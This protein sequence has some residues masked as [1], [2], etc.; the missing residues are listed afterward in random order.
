MSPRRAAT[1]PVR[2]QTPQ[3]SDIDA[4]RTQADA[5]AARAAE[6]RKIAD[7]AG[8]LYASLDEGQR[9]RL[10]RGVRM[11]GARGMDGHEGRGRRW[12][13]GGWDD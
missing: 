8:P 9:N 6:M 3:V 11:V 4:M 12:Q 5:L 13:R 7:A 2:S 10:M 1:S